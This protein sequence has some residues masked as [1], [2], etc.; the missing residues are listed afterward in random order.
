MK[1]KLKSE[2]ETKKWNLSEKSE[3]EIKKVKLKPKMKLKMKLKKINEIKNNKWNLS[4]NICNNKI[5]YIKLN[6]TLIFLLYV[7][8]C[9]SFPGDDEWC[10]REKGHFRPT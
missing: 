4:S 3:I 5:N 10:D 2:I 7:A 9:K 1:L 6:E 8:Y